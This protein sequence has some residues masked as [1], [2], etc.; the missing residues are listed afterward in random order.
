MY[1]IKDKATGT[2]Q[3]RFQVPEGHTDEWAIDAIRKLELGRHDWQ[4]RLTDFGGE[5]Y[6]IDELTRIEIIKPYRTK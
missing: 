6:R 5:F 4:H 3:F 1:D 2:I